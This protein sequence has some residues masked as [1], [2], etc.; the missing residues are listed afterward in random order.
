MN[1]DEAY[2]DRL[3]GLVLWN[4]YLTGQSRESIEVLARKMGIG[5]PFERTRDC[6]VCISGMERIAYRLY[7]VSAIAYDNLTSELWESTLLPMCSRHG[8]EGV[9]V[10]EIYHPFKHLIYLLSPLSGAGPAQ[11]LAQDLHACLESAF[12]ETFGVDLKRHGNF[13]VCS[14]RLRG[15]TE[16]M[17]AFE[18]LKDLHQRTFFPLEQRCWTE[19]ELLLAGNQEALESAHQGMRD[20]ME[21][22]YAREE[23]RA[24]EL[25]GMIC[26]GLERSMDRR[27]CIR[28]A[29]VLGEQ[30]EEACR[31]FGGTMG[32]KAEVNLEK[33]EAFQ[34]L[35]EVMGAWVEK[36]LEQIPKEGCIRSSLVRSAIKYMAGHFREPLQLLDV[37]RYCGVS[38]A[39]LSRLFNRETGKSIP[40]YL[41]ELRLQSARK[42][43]LQ[44]AKPVSE[45]A[46]SNGF[47]SDTYFSRMFRKEYGMTPGQMR[48]QER[49]RKRREKP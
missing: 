30:L 2:A 21:A 20:L 6:Y 4:E 29:M 34:S 9:Y 16:I 3:F 7:G 32:E 44:S 33:A 45:I 19:E 48:E 8:Y 15:Q 42:R 23:E 43:L 41:L 49:D 14:S 38:D 46:L 35:A 10:M 22:V 27:G 31:L 11:E 24:R 12:E 5:F 36:A 28:F 40:A 18:R 13:T 25:L 17:G 26:A 37:A 39:Y 1:R 47:S